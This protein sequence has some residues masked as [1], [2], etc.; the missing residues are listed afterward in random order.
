M[1]TVADVVPGV[2]STPAPQAANTVKNNVANLVVENW[3]KNVI[4]QLKQSSVTERNE[5]QRLNVELKSYLDSTKA[6]ENLNKKLLDDVEKARNRALPT[7]V[8]KSEHDKQL[9]LARQKLEHES[10]EVVKTQIKVEENQSLH[11]HLSDRIR[12]FAKEADLQRE[13]ILALQ[14]QL[15]DLS[16]QRES[17][18]RSAKLAEDDRKREEERAQQVFRLIQIIILLNSA[19]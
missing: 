4:S 19:N 3:T 1:T 18:L 10:L 16:G 2:A 17:L 14:N 12:F 13:K 6:L 7:I 5:L 8:D 15:Q 11:Q 9:D